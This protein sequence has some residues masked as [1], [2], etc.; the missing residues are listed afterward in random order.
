MLA[1][2]V[3]RHI[4]GEGGRSTIWRDP[5]GLDSDYDY[6]PVWA[7]CLELKLVPTFHNS[8]QGLGFR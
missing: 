4:P 8:T 3:N 1:G 5:L 2:L 7:K 6:D